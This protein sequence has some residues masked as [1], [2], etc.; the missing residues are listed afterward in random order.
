LNSGEV[1]G[2]HP[3]LGTRAAH[4]IDGGTS[5]DAPSGSGEGRGKLAEQIAHQIERDIVARGWPVGEVI[6][7][8]SELIARFGVSRAAVR[9]SVRLLE[10]HTTARMRPGPGG[11]LTVTAPSSEAITHAMALYLE[12]LGVSEAQ[13]FEARKVIELTAVEGATASITEAGVQLLRDALK[14]E[15]GADVAELPQIH[16]NIHLRIA[17]LSG[18]PVLPLFVKVLADVWEARL[19]PLT[20]A[21]SDVAGDAEQAHAAIVDAIVRG[22]GALARHRMMRH[23]EAIVPWLD[24]V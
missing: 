1:S 8:E 20:Y 6:G 5:A 23:L 4:N 11:G 24:R 2:A 17:E 18:N 9:E 15:H 12:Y 7:S 3:G 14:V 10:H 13:V 22:D 16:R 19:E 21:A